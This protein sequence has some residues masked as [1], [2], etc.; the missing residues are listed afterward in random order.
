MLPQNRLNVIPPTPQ[1]ITMLYNIN[2]IINTNSENE[3]KLLSE[4]ENIELL[5][6]RSELQKKIQ[7]HKVQQLAEIKAEMD[8]I[9]NN[10]RYYFTQLQDKENKCINTTTTK[11]STL[12]DRFK[13]LE[14]SF[15]NKFKNIN[16]KF[17]SENQLCNVIISSILTDKKLDIILDVVKHYILMTSGEVSSKE[18]IKHGIEYTEKDTIYPKGLFKDMLV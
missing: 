15:L 5:Y 3:F 2:A 1:E 9:K 8:V 12:N 6:K 18:C 7:E 17:K 11:L 4:P 13:E 14:E 16:Y 10:I